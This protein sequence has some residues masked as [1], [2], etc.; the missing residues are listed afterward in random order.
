MRRARIGALGDP[1][2]GREGPRRRPRAPSPVRA[3]PA[4]RGADG[5]AGRRRGSP[6]PA[7]PEG[8]AGRGRGRAASGASPA[9]AGRTGAPPPP[10]GPGQTRTTRPPRGGP[11]GL[12][13]G[14]RAARSTRGDGPYLL[15]LVTRP[16]PTVRPPSRMAKRRPSSIATGWIRV[17]DMST[18]SPGMTISVPSGSFTTPVTSVVRK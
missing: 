17:T 14:R 15:I 13:A 2:P 9:G 5:A 16:A 11:G 4:T 7:G 12:G 1:G 6:A 3:T 10:R 8:P 18:L